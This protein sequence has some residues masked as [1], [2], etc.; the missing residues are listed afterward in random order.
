[1]WLHHKLRLYLE[2]NGICRVCKSVCEFNCKHVPL[3]KDSFTVDHVVPRS[4]GGRTVTKNLVG[5]CR[6]CN[7]AKGNKHMKQFLN[8]DRK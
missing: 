3:C 7:Q 5:M 2:Q 8:S 4:K 6:Q 1:M